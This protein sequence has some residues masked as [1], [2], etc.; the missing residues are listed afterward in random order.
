MKKCT[1]L[2]KTRF[3]QNAP[4][5]MQLTKIDQNSENPASQKPSQRKPSQPNR[6]KSTQLTK[7]GW[8]RVSQSASKS[9]QLTKII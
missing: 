8:Y 7:N 2:S 6:P 3:T 4:K 5:S 9:T 1:K